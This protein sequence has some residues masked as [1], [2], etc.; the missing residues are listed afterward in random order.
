MT[1]PAAILATIALV[2]LA[3]LAWPLVVRFG[4]RDLAEPFSR[5]DDWGR[6]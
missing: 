6:Q 3:W 4:K 1:A 5:D 2:A